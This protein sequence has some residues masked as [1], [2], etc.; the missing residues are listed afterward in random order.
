MVSDSAAFVLLTEDFSR[1]RSVGSTFSGFPKSEIMRLSA[2]KA[3]PPEI[4]AE[5]L[6]TSP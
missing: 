2:A 5:A 1:S 4:V 6:Q 3:A